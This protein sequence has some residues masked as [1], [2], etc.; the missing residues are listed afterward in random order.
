MPHLV[1]HIHGKP[2]CVSFSKF[3]S[4]ICS[5]NWRYLYRPY[6]NWRYLINVVQRLCTLFAVY[7]IPTCALYFAVYHRTHRGQYKYISRSCFVNIM[8]FNHITFRPTDNETYE[9]GIFAWLVFN[10][11]GSCTQFCE[12]HN[13]K[14]NETLSCLCRSFV[15][16][17]YTIVSFFTLLLIVI[18]KKKRNITTPYLNILI[19]VAHVFHAY[20]KPFDMFF[21]NYKDLYKF[22]MKY[23]KIY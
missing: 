6:Y 12:T 15:H 16:P 13:M 10:Y 22:I 7:C 19:H 11:K 9:G 18:Q 23:I 2:F 5:T 3:Q 20:S 14:L 8:A 1:E 4:L 21:P 17:I